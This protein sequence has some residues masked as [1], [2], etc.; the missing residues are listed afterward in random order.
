[1]S[2]IYETGNFFLEYTIPKDRDI[3]IDFQVKA[4]EGRYDDV[5]P[6]FSYGG[7]PKY[8]NEP[9]SI[10]LSGFIRRLESAEGE[11]AL[12]EVLSELYYLFSGVVDSYL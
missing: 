5:D 9:E 1:M 7:T 2:P 3:D 11:K 8:A 4:A 6:N 12:N 10:D